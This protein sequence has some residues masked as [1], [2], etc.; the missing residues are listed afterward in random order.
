MVVIS[1]LAIGLVSIIGIVL[2]DAYLGTGVVT[3]IVGSLGT[4]F[5]AAFSGLALLV[6]ELS[7]G[8]HKT[9]ISPML[10]TLGLGYID[11]FII[12][13]FGFIFGALEF[14]YSNLGFIFVIAQIIIILITLKENDLSEYIRTFITLE[15][16][17]F[18]SVFMVVYYIID[19]GYKILILGTMNIIT[20]MIRVV[21]G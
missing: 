9:I 13:L 17:F 19:L 18:T 10:D 20:S 12:V 11:D 16:T 21:R 3:E 14:A 2:T 6:R 8:F 5:A 1:L 4:G 7:L 15:I